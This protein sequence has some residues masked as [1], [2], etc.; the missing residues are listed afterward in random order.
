MIF[1][2]WQYS[3][4]ANYLRPDLAGMGIELRGSSSGTCTITPSSTGAMSIVGG[5]ASAADLTLR[6]TAHATPGSVVA[7][8]TLTAR[9]I[10]GTPGVDDITTAHDG[11]NGAITCLSGN[12]AI[13]SS[14]GDFNL[15]AAS[16]AVQS[17]A[18]VIAREGLR[19]WVSKN[20][21]FYNDAIALDAGL[22]RAGVSSVEVNNGTIGALG[23]LIAAKVGIGFTAPA[24]PLQ[25][26]GAISY[27]ALGVNNFRVGNNGNSPTALWENAS[28]R[29]SVD[30]AA[31]VMRWLW[32]AGA[33]I[34]MTLDSAGAM[35]LA[36][37]IVAEGSGNNKFN[38]LGGNF[39][40]GVSGTPSG[41]QIC[42]SV[43]PAAIGV[44]CVRMGMNSASPTTPSLILE[45]N[46]SS[47]QWNIDNAAGELRF[48]R[49]NATVPFSFGA[50]LM[51]FGEASN[52]AVGTGTG[53]KIGTVGG[54][55][56]Q[57]LAFWNSTPILQPVLAT[58]AAA[59]VDNVITVLQNLGLVRQS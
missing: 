31:D 21:T 23:N 3:P 38:I 5:S 24:S 37:N 35:T 33:T 1:P 8:G 17:H 34:P 49:N 44:D 47:V 11:S 29:Y 9:Q 46:T 48:V 50:T 12:L 10:G 18:P 57:K 26:T 40:I 43:N 51:T 20:L 22:A 16:G 4:T 56:G 54:A 53:T 41:L 42:R 14:I 55:S 25:I 32:E 19:L 58:G 45:N 30:L 15:H 6:G 2:G 13:T 27:T 28:G 59:T 52:V 39:G 36:G 7:L